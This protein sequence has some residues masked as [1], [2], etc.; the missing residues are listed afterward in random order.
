MLKKKRN[1]RTGEMLSVFC[2]KFTCFAGK[3]KE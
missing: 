3:R 2:G 1:K